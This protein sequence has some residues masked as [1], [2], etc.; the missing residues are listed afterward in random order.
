MIGWNIATENV[1]K[2]KYQVMWKLVIILLSSFKDLETLTGVYTA[3]QDIKIKQNF[4]LE[5]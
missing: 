4:E 1:E 2:S 5:T 3:T